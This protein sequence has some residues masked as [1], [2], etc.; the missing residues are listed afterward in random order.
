MANGLASQEQFYQSQFSDTRGLPAG[1]VF[2]SIRAFEAS[3]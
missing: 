1:P 3:V 2:G